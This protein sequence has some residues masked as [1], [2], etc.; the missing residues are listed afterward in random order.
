MKRALLVSV[1][2]GAALIT[3]PRAQ[4]RVVPLDEEQGHVARGLA[5]RHLSNTGIFMHTT[6][7]PDDENNGLLVMMNRGMGYRT[8]LATATRGNGGQNEIGPEIFEAL[9]LLRTGEL[10]A[11]HRFDGAEQYFTRAVDFGYSFSIEETFEKW[12]RGEI[13]ADYVRLIRTIRPDVIITL[14]Q[15]GNAGGQHH[16]ASAVITHDAFKLAGDPTKYPEQIREGLRPWQPR[17]LYES[18]G[19]GFPGEE[20]PSG[21]LTHVNS[22]VYDTLLG[23]TYAEIGS[24]A[25]SMHKCQGMGQLLALPSPAEQSTYK[26]VETT[27]Q[28]QNQKD[29][30]SF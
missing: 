13:T 6:A 14:P 9:G 1:A 30:T 8:A 7:H 12:G 26:P 15:T 2:V 24:E 19:F 22:G 18:G 4:M 5:L 27:M 16:M 25:R 21:R 3:I 29:E 11:L 23:R 10:A 20:Q 28:P 17:K